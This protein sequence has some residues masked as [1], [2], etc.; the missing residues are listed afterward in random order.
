MVI[1]RGG[2]GSGKSSIVKRVGDRYVVCSADHFLV[3]DD[4]VYEWNQFRAGRAHGSCFRLC[5]ENVVI[6]KDVLIDNTNCKPQEMIPYLALCSAFGYTCTVIRTVCDPEIAWRRQTH[7]VDREK[8]DKFFTTVAQQ[9]V[10]KLYRDEL[11][12][13]CVDVRTDGRFGPSCTCGVS[14]GLRNDHE[15]QCAAA[16][17]AKRR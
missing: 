16:Y 13:T 5:V 1:M 9:Q 8:F 10:P 7:D 14:I 11:W 6:G 4:G 3:N 12:L 15:S 17:V 2:P